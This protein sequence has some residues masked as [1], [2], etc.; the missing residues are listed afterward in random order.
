[1]GYASGGMERCNVKTRIKE[2]KEKLSLSP[3]EFA[4]SVNSKD[5]FFVLGFPTFILL[6]LVTDMR[7]LLF[8]T[9]I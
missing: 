6:Q 1:M 8:L 5:K 4:L 9:E 3:W 2:L 7:F